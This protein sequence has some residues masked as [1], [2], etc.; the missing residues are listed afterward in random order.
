MSA[1]GEIDVPKG[2]VLFRQGDPADAM[3]VVA[4]GRVRL[5]LGTG[6]EQ[7]E[8]GTLGPGAFFG[9]VSLITGGER[10]ASAEVIEDSRLLVVDR[11]AFRMLVQDDLAIVTRM[12]NV[13]GARLT[14]TNQP[15]QHGV[16][17]LARVRAIAHALGA[18]GSAM[19]LPARIPILVLA[20]DFGTT[21][22]ALG[23]V[24]RDLIA[25]GAGSR[26]A[27][28]WTVATPSEVDALIAALAAYAR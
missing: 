22:E 3:Y 24:I 4:A 27:D 5:T 23:D 15:I 10:T 1:N 2:T 7:Q 6:V 26:D 13:Q 11:D 14:R 18:I 20:D 8:I 12:L 21:P 19:A 16:Q 17:R 28:T 25:R 9:E